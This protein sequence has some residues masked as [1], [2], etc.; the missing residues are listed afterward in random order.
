MEYLIIAHDGTDAGAKE[1]RFQSRDAHLEGVKRMME[2]GT[3]VNG[4][5]ILDDA[6]TMIGSTLYVDFETRAEL[7]Q[8]LKDDPYITG[9]V[10][11]NINV[12]PIRLVFRKK[13]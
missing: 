9:G 12:Q 8:W 1:R 7:D 11:E 13:V 3:F 5:A 10:W 2:A 6:G 4:G